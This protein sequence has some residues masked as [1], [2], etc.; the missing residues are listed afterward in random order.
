[1]AESKQ[2]QKEQEN[3]DYNFKILSN[4][5]NDKIILFLLYQKMEKKDSLQMDGEKDIVRWIANEGET[6]A[7]NNSI[8]EAPSEHKK[9]WSHHQRWSRHGAGSR[10]D[11]RREEKKK[12]EY[13][14]T[15]LEVRRV[16]R[17]TSGW[18][19]LAFRALML[20]GN[21]KGKIGLGIA[22][23]NDV[24]IAI[25]KATHDAKKNLVDVP[26]NDAKSVPY[27]MT[28]KFKA[29]ILKLI[30]AKPGTGLKAGSSIRSVL[31]LAGYANILSKMIGTNNTLNN[32]LA[33]IKA[34]GS[35]KLKKNGKEIKTETQ[36]TTIRKSNN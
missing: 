24:T 13:D 23:G 15:M 28:I 26:M 11:D 29:A 9:E 30:P 1:M 17:V 27:P 10:N 32:A 2:L 25:A 22:K 36:K 35:Y 31:E 4:W 21:R 7:M 5:W 16:T 8:E 34:L 20:I 33:T 6:P 3:R 18:R 19:Q 14:E 12:K